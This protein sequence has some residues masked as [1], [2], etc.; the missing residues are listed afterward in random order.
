[1]HL[2][3]DNL[4][5]PSMSPIDSIKHLLV[6]IEYKDDKEKFLFDLLSTC[7]KSA[8]SLHIAQ[9]PKEDQQKELNRLK[10]S[11]AS[12]QLQPLFTEYMKNPSF[13]NIYQQLVRQ[14]M[15]PYIQ[16]ALPRLNRVNRDELFKFLQYLEKTQ[17]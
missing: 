16:D 7:S 6:L 10:E 14:Y 8:I 9:L 2:T 13:M 17:K 11:A 5:T 3:D 1:M 15:E 4:S 12:K